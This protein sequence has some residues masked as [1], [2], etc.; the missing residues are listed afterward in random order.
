VPPTPTPRANRWT[1]L[2]IVM[3]GLFAFGTTTTVLAAS[4]K[5]VAEGLDSSTTVLAWAI[6][7]PF[8]SMGIGNPVFGKLGDI[9]GRRRFYLGGMA[10]FAAA[11]AASAF[12][13]GAGALIALRALAGLGAAAAMPTGTALILDCFTLAERP[14]ALGVYNL[15]G[16]G[17]PA[18]GLVLGGPM[19]DAFGWRAVFG[20]YGVI[21]IIGLVL[22]VAVVPGDRGGARVPVDIAGSAALGTATLGLM[23]GMS[24]GERTSFTHVATLG[25]LALCPL[26]IAW[27]VLAERRASHPLVPLPYFA[28]PNFAGPLAGYFLAHIAYMGA[29]VVTPILLDDV[30]GYA[31]S[32]A[33]AILLLRPLSFSLASPVGGRLTTAIG[34]RR[35]SV[36]SAAVLAGSMALFATG[37]SLESIVLVVVAL[38]VSGMCLGACS[39]SY[40]SAVTSAAEPHEL[41]LATG[42]LSTAAALGTVVG[43][44]TAVLALGDG[45]PHGASD[46]RLP[47]LIGAVAAGLMVLASWVLRPVPRDVTPTAPA[48]GGATLLPAEP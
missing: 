41:G 3:I 25:V 29:F 5:E 32:L 43:I 15:I 46:F 11:T 23:L 37:S 45:E 14:R 10:V 22:S 7:G 2:C 26:G 12:A 19:I 33:T 42:M 8:L 20:I 1:V 4:L 47:Y 13:P 28:R 44:Q 31:L 18:I 34:E 16:T 9:Y 6:T 21:G 27:F 35:T 30:F 39:P 17:A 48:P 24:I 40:M 38:S 36:W